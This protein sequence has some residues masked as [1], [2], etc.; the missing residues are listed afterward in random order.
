MAVNKASNSSSTDRRNTSETR[1][2]Q[3]SQLAYL[4]KEHFSK[5]STAE[6]RE[7]RRLNESRTFVSSIEPI[8][9]KRNYTARKVENSYKMEPTVKFPASQITEIAN[10]VLSERLGGAEYDENEC[11]ELS[12]GLCNEIQSKIKLLNMPRYKFVCYVHIGQIKGQDMVIAS[13]CL[14]D[15]NVDNFASAKF[16]NRSL[17]ATV[18]V[19]G[20]YYE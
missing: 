7:S 16:E 4:S 8:H 19:F 14:W 5:P 9:L 13:R 10:E 1:K 18:S 15:T 17:F 12:K 20:F 3:G 11:K 2:K 6:Q